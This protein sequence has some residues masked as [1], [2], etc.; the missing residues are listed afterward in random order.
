MIIFFSIFSS[1][2][3]LVQWNSFSNFGTGQGEEHFCEIDLKLADWS[4]EV[5]KDVYRVHINLVPVHIENL[6]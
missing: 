6:S 5:D 4:S 1:G 3:H 2:G